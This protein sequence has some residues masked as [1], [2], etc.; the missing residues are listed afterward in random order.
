MYKTYFPESVGG[1]ER[2]IHQLAE[3]GQKFG[4]ESRVLAL[5]KSQSFKSEYVD[6]HRV[7]YVPRNFEFA[8]T[9]FS[10][11]AIKHLRRCAKEVDL[12]HYHFPWPF[13]D[14]MHFIAGVKTP[15]ILTYHSDIIRQKKLLWLYRPLMLLFMRQ[16][17]RIVATSPNYLIS[18]T[19]LQRYRNKVTVIPLGVDAASYPMP[20]PDLLDRWKNEVG[21]R[22]FIFVGVL[23]YYKGLNILLDALALRE[24]PMVIVGVGP[25]EKDLK[26]QADRLG[27]K[28][29][30]FLGCV[31]E[32]DKIALIELS[33]AM[34]FPSHLR[35][36]AFGMSLVEGAMCG[37]PMISCE[38]GTGTSFVNEHRVT[39]LVVTPSD[40]VALSSAMAEIWDAPEEVLSMGAAAK[41]RY[42]NFFT[43]ELMARR[44]AMLYD[45]VLEKEAQ[46]DC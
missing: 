14:L 27:L 25:V 26:A 29:I 31:S 32:E 33:V 43:A 40:E 1:V 21:E 24:F 39:G 6:S 20:S 34:V 30:K 37:K 23:R 10:W 38:I 3:S 8:S 45:E 22:F 17:K 41:N 35:S 18:S 7:D 44:Y 9:G 5:S 28:N 36:E 19:I 13:M 12:V 15:C 11:A 4:V 16:V 46:T 2:V 42:Q